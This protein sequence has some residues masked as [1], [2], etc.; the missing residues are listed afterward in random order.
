MSKPDQGRSTY[1][2]ERRR[3]EAGYPSSRAGPPHALPDASAS[4]ASASPASASSRASPSPQSVAI[5]R[6]PATPPA[7]LFTTATLRRAWLGVKRSG[8]GAGVDG[9]TIQKFE[10]DLATEL[11][12]LRQ[13]LISGEYQPQ[14]I[15]RILVP[16]PNGGLRPLALWALRDRIAQRAIYEIIAPAFEVI[17]LPCSFGFRPGV[18]VQEALARL[19]QLRDENRRWVVDADIKDCFDNIDPQRLLGLVAERVDDPLLLRYIAG[20]LAARIFNTADGIPQKAGASQGSVLSPLL[21]NI[22][23]HQIDVALTG[24]ELALVRYADD[25]VV[26]CQRKSEAQHALVAVHDTL[27]RWGLQL[28]EKKTQLVHFDQGFTWLGYFFVRGECYQV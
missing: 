20:W 17:F 14:P 26:C 21:A 15:R 23:L 4:P 24:A 8:G 3:N 11:S 22:Y 25:L 19:Q 18:G 9:M 16:K 1:Q 5:D 13:Q 7:Q 27:H 10:A 28:N 2:Q 12:T 6:V